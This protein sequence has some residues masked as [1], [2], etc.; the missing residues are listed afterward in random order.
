MKP[1]FFSPLPSAKLPRNTVLYAV[2][3][4]VIADLLTGGLTV[5]HD[6]ANSGTSVGMIEKHYGK[7]RAQVARKALGGLKSVMRRR[8]EFIRLIEVITALTESIDLDPAFRG[9][10][11]L[12]RH[13]SNSVHGVLG[14]QRV[15]DRVTARNAWRRGFGL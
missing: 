2:R 8:L 14:A 3:H 6:G 10:I 9:A 11:H 15:G 12:R 7:L 1:R 5:V 4:S 13:S